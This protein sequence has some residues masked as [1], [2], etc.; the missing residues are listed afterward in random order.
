ML[1]AQYNIGRLRYPLDDPRMADFT[2]NVDRI[3]ALAERIDGFVWRL[4]GPSGNALD[5]GPTWDLVP[6]ITLWRSVESLRRFAYQTAHRHFIARAAEWFLPTDG[7]KLVM[8]WVDDN[9]R[10][11][12]DEGAARLLRLAQY[13]PH[14]EAFGF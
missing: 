11:T 6:N 3:N 13:G 8:W 1:L 2:S 14:Q 5:M 7:P 4:S 10:P 9:H 12:M